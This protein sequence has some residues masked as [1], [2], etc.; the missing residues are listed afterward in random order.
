M[1]EQSELYDFKLIEAT[2]LKQGL[3]FNRI[4]ENEIEVTIAPKMVL[5]IANEDDG[6]DTSVGFR[7]VP[8]HWH[9]SLTLVTGESTYVEYDPSE[10]LVGLTSGH[11]IVVTQYLKGQL[12]DRWLAHR[13]EKMDVRYMEPE[14]ELRI[15]RAAALR[16]GT[17]VS[18]SRE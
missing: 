5:L 12:Q 17:T 18:E 11:V 8:S 9:G 15:Y 6:T 1:G 2:C 3:S 10:V 16:D 13:D 14:E 4:S 7:D